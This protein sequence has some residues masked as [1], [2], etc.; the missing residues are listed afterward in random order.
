MPSRPRPASPSGRYHFKSKDDLVAAY[1][2]AR[3]QPNLALFKRWFTEAD[4]KLPDKVEA[5]FRHLARSAR[6]PKWKGCGFLRTTAELANMPGHPAIKIGAAHKKKF[7]D[8]L[9]ATFEAEGIDDAL[10][11][12]RQILLLLDGS[13]AVVLLHRDPSYM[14]TAGRAASSL[15]AAALPARSKSRPGKARA[16]LRSR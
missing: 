2:A 13:F 3:D 14:E 8:W 15:I 9:R 16:T 7:E 10:P 11:L 1:L 5:I 6:H 4:G 12:A